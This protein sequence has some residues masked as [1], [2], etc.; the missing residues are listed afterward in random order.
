MRHSVPLWA[1]IVFGF[2]L[3]VL[4]WWPALD[5]AAE[6]QIDASL[7]RALAAFA[8]ARGIDAVISAAQGTELALQPAGIGLTLSPGELLDPVN[9]LVERFSGIMLMASAS[10]G[11]QK[12]L[13][14]VSGWTPLWVVLSLAI[15]TYLLLRMDGRGGARVGLDWLRPLLLVLLIVR[16]AVPLSALA[17]EAAYRAFLADEYEQA[18]SL[19]K[20]E[21]DAIGKAATSDSALPPRVKPAQP[22]APPPTL[23]ERTRQWFGEAR[24]TFNS[25]FD[26]RAAMERKMQHLKEIASQ[27][28]EKIIQLIAI[29]II[30]TLVFPLLFLWLS[31]QALQ[32]GLPALWRQAANAPRFT[33]RDDPPRLGAP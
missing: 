15:G 25:K 4:C 24:E 3:L 30:Q 12:L 17:S 28:T 21:G 31:W 29:F 19:L 23:L 5:S 18:S 8:I 33:E 2:A 27:M 10:L 13:L 14:N 1:Q 26:V 6:A 20:S 11:L 7:K 9:D 16:F 32:V 22:V